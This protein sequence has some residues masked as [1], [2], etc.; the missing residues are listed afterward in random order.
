MQVQIHNVEKITSKLIIF[1]DFNTL[2]FTVT[3]DNG[4]ETEFK[5]Y[6]DDLEKLSIIWEAPS[7]AY[8]K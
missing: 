2:T 7:N 5:L 8:N 4:T 3:D 1:N 6:S